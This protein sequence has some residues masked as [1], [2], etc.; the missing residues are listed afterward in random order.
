V[1]QRAPAFALPDVDGRVVTLDALRTRG[2]AVVV[3]YRGDW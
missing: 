2:P 1:R 3:F